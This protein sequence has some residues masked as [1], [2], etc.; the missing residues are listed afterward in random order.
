MCSCYLV[1]R[2]Q[3][4][5]SLTG[6][7]SLVATCLRTAAAGCAV[8]R[9]KD[10]PAHLGDRDREDRIRSHPAMAA[11]GLRSFRDPQ[12]GLC[13]R[14]WLA[15]HGYSARLARSQQRKVLGFGDAPAPCSGDPIP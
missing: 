5:L 7:V 9:R 8:H 1:A 2:H 4:L 15:D 3:D 11:V 12:L 10:G 6:D 14:A 13:Q